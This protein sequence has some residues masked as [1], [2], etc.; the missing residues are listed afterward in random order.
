MRFYIVMTKKLHYLILTVMI[1]AL[2]TM[3]TGC[4][5]DDFTTSSSD[6]LTFSTDTVAFD[7]VITAQSTPTK[8]F[9]V[10]NRSDKMVNISSI[11]IAGKAKGKFYLNVD[12]VKGS[13]FH[14]IEI[15]GKDS[16][17][18]FVESN[19]DVT[20][21]DEPVETTDRIDF[22]TNGVTQSVVLTAWGQDVN[23]ISGDTVKTDTHLGAGKPYLVYD[24]LVVAQ[25]ATL[26]IDPGVTLLFHAKAG[27]KVEGRLLAQGSQ[28]RPI[29]LRGDRLDHVVGQINFDIM[30]G[31]WG[32]VQFGRHS[33]G[34]EM[35]Y[36]EM[37][38]STLG[39]TVNPDTCSQM[40][41][42]IF[43]SVLHNSSSS[44]L[45]ATNA[46]V[47]AEGTELSDAAGSVA[48]FTGGKV[49]LTQCTLANYYL[50]D[51]ISGAILNLEPQDEAKTYKILE[52]QVDNCI[53]Y[54]NT[55]ELN[56]GDL[57]GTGI[58]LRN[59]LLKSQG[60]DD[61]NFISCVW[62]GDPMFYTERE[63]YIF[64]YR[65]RNKSEAIATGNRAYCPDAA[66]YDRYGQDRFAREGLDLGAYVWVEATETDG[67]KSPAWR[68]ARR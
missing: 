2:T 31:Q 47:E 28:E 61:A 43:N 13:E 48:S 39:V 45:T 7:T 33:Y 14:N 58:M 40:A 15:R 42:H 4:I 8:Q 64:D 11:S 10:Y 67:T 66:R 57:T 32:G 68:Q 55:A 49:R 35:A 41:L 16:I 53:I 21:A 18:V 12:G 63:K 9:M 62:G 1:A 34:N 22:V 5:N 17:Y 50:F 44:V 37:R 19:I 46:W 6:V 24:T 29:V 20:G 38:G 26:T 51:A 25:G 59:C 36:V 54:G 60:S 23:I 30:S 65:L 52:A 27:M 3:G 56:N